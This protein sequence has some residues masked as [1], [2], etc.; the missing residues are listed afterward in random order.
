M[1]NV[2]I[3]DI[4]VNDGEETFLA[5]NGSSVINLCI[6]TGSLAKKT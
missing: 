4:I 1:E 2:A 6:V 5:S 3:D